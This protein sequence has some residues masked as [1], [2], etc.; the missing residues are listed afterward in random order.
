MWYKWGKSL[1]DKAILGVKL[2]LIDVG[3]SMVDLEVLVVLVG[4]L[5]C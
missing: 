1:G 3:E 5:G 4:N 2:R